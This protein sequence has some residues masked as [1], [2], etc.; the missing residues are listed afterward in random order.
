M[1]KRHQLKEA[2]GIDR[3]APPRPFAYSCLAGRRMP[4]SSFL[5][6]RWRGDSH[7]GRIDERFLPF[8][9]H[10]RRRAPC[11]GSQRPW[12]AAGAR[13]KLA[14]PPRLR[15]RQ[16]SEEHTSELQSLMRISD[17]VFFLKKKK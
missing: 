6:Q 8:A 3:V 2:E 7:R 1:P 5:P 12:P 14:D 4:L 9:H 10:V 16:R 15:R 17:A 13:G 11:L